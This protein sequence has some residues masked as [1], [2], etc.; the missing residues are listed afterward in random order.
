M[1]SRGQGSSREQSVCSKFNNVLSNL[2]V[3]ESEALLW[4]SAGGLRSKVIDSQGE[5]AKCN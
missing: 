3:S 2:R 5:K 4:V 1:N